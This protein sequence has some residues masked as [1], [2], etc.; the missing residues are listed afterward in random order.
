MASDGMGSAKHALLILPQTLTAD[1]T[2]G[3][4]EGPVGSLLG[5]LRWSQ[6]EREVQTPQ[7]DPRLSC[8]CQ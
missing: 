2:A 7:K 4:A 1:S 6:R 3:D 8:G 5:A